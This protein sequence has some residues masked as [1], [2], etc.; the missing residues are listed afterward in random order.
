MENYEEAHRLRLLDVD[1]LL[2]VAPP[3]STA[4][5]HLGG[6]AVEC[7]LKALILTYHKINVWDE[8]SKRVGDPRHKRP[9]QRTS[10]ALRAAVKLMDVLYKKAQAD[11]QFLKHLESV[12][13]PA[14]ANASDF[15]ALRYSGSDLGSEIFPEWRRSL[16]Y[17]LGWLKKNEVLL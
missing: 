14:G 5:A 4:A 9:I 3:R 2:A 16:D 11:P 13:Y 1:A 8:P 17:V 6:V 12:T 15:I 10:H 7:R